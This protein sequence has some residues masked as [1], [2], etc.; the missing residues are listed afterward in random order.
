V[1]EPVSV[2]SAAARL[3]RPG[4]HFIGSTINR[5]MRAWLTAIV[6]G[7]HII[8]LL[9]KGT[10]EYARFIRPSELASWLRAAGFDVVD[11]CGLGYLPWADRA[12][13]TADTGVNY[14]IHARLAR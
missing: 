14:L 5:T 10:H 4:G 8:R 2:I 12:V 9:P 6:G 13:L 7:E 3:L 11:V 1:P